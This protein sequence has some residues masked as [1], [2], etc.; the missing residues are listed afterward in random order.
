MKRLELD[1]KSM[2]SVSRHLKE[3]DVG[4]QDMPKIGTEGGSDVPYYLTR[5]S[6]EITT[7]EIDWLRTIP[8]DEPEIFFDSQEPVSE[9]KR[10]VDKNAKELLGFVSYEDDKEKN[11]DHIQD[12]NSI[13]LSRSEVIWLTVLPTMAC[14]GVICTAGILAWKKSLFGLNNRRYHGELSGRVRHVTNFRPTYK[15]LSVYGTSTS[16]MILP[17][18]QERNILYVEKEIE[19][20]KAKGEADNFEISYSR[21]ILGKEIGKGAFGRVFLAQAE[22]IGN[23]PGFTTVAVKKLKYKATP[24]ELEE[25]QAEIAMMKKVGRHPNIVNIIGCCTISQPYCMLMEY[26]PCGD[27]LQYLRQLRHQVKRP[28]PSVSSKTNISSSSRSSESSSYVEPDNGTLTSSLFSSENPLLNEFP[29]LEYVLDPRELQSFAFQIAN[30]M[31]HLES[32]HITHRDLAA[33][34][35]LVDK[36]KTLK[37]SDFGLSRTGIYVNTKHKK[38]PLRWLSIEAMRDSLYSSKSDVWAFGIVLWEIGTLGGFPYPTVVDYELLNYLLQGNRLEK[39]ANCSDELYSLM[40][41]CWSHS[42]DARPTFQQLVTCLDTSISNKRVYVNFD[43]LQNY[44]ILPPTEQQPVPKI[45][46]PSETKT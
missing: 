39:P 20:A 25:F 9:I 24:D 2:E 33:R 11:I 23:L 37:I 18:L 21:I 1:R 22:A 14:V 43:D 36:N 30:G 46:S 8:T 29:K 15:S 12:E 32:K 28:L 17:S 3:L 34:N 42:A 44:I 19:D 38:V 26:I 10:R 31:S 40:I 35:I 41:H 5:S 13:Q 45:T 6:T 4:Q 16:R 7:E 27:L